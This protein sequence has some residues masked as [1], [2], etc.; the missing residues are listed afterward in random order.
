MLLTGKYLARALLLSAYALF[1]SPSLF[2]S[3]PVDS[4][5]IAFF[6][7]KVRPLLVERCYECH[8]TEA[9]KSKGGLLLDTR[10]G[11]V[12][13]GDTGPALEPGD[14]DGSLLLQAVRYLDKDLQM[15]PK[16]RLSAEEVGI[17][18]TWIRVGAP[19]PRS[20]SR[21]AAAGNPGEKARKHWA[22][23]PIA[24][25]QPP[26]V[27]REGWGTSP[28]DR[29]VLASLEKA[30]LQP[31]PPADRRTLIRR[32]YFDIVG[33]PPTFEEMEAF[34]ADPSPDAPAKLVEKLLAQ[35]EYGQRW[36]RYWLDVA[37]YS[38]TREQSVDAE[39]RY[40]FAWTYRDYVIEAL[41]RDKPF[42]AFIREQIAAD[43][44]PE[45]EH[46]SLAALGFL[47]VGRRFLGNAD[48]GNLVI[49]DRIDV[50]TR[51]FMGLTV[52]CARCHDHKFDPVPT[53]DYYSL[54]G[55]MAS[56]EEPMDLPVI[57]RSGDDAAVGKYLVE[58]QKVFEEYEQ[59]ID[60]CLANANR[61]MR[62]FAMENLQYLVQMLPNHR[63]TEGF[64]PLDTPRGLLLNGGPE[65]WQRLLDQSAR[66][67]ESLFAPWRR[68][69]E[70][71]AATFSA[72][73]AQAIADL[74][75]QPNHVH[76]WLLAALQA[77]RPASMLEVAEAYGQVIARSLAETGSEAEEV[78][79]LVYGASSPVPVTRQEMIDELAGFLTTRKLTQRDESV[80]AGTL[81]D[82]LTAVEAGSPVQHAMVVQPTR[83]PFSPHILIR[84]NATQ[85]G[86]AVPRRFITL[87]GDVDSREYKTDGRLELAQAVASRKNPLTARV[88]VNRVWQQ[89]FGQPLV[90]SVDNFGLSGEAPSHP[91]LLD[92]LATWLMD[93]G[94]SLKALHRYILL[95]NTWQ[96]SSAV[97]EDGSEVDVANRWLWRMNARRLEFEPLRDSLLSV[98][99]RLDARSGGQSEPMTGNSRRRAVYGYTDR[100]TIP[101]LMRTFDVA[102]PDTSISRRSETTVPQQALFMM[103]SPF[104]RE[105]A[106]AVIDR[107][108]IASDTEPSADRVQALFR[109]VLLRNPGPDELEWAT[110]YMGATSGDWIKRWTTFSQALL[111]SN[112]FCFIN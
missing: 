58:R 53:A 8:S 43:L 72:D 89:H 40:P 104:V 84:G 49:D 83:E 10:D 27:R 15:P 78:R 71:K 6:E 79:D 50:I 74:A 13:G 47:T 3:E 103:N 85:P 61:Q 33:L 90:A 111:L 99:G 4:E 45:R 94:W 48:A 70:L 76:P 105:Q 108:Q 73:A 44:L 18:E 97:R 56:A 67:G 51:G 93:H 16:N 36:G 107:L 100:F 101:P 7:A 39:R 75:A 96:Q 2:G 57:G 55:I 29:F 80:H 21:S 59:H 69:V 86:A 95:S 102:S 42:D 66:D 106:R 77:R 92:H 52:S 110:E 91:E 12:K 25:P 88:I 9:N 23:Q 65:R 109:A 68:L 112:E 81:R 24:N 22:F 32:L 30:G 54:F 82:K 11:W 17:F 60:K 41:N 46:K 34:F 19:D 35:P 62:E 1:P 28:L 26:V 98:A 63:T 37:R 64:I 14:L 20:G 31:N 38:D 87:L 5:A